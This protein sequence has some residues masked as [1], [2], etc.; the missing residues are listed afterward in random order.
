MKGK[1]L[2][3]AGI[4]ILLVSVLLDY[5]GIGS[6]PGFGAVQ[7]AG[8]LLGLVLILLGVRGLRPRKK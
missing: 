7:I 8:T 4:I 6:K 5:I 3:I 1:I 2:L